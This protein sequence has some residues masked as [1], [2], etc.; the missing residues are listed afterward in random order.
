MKS[1][2]TTRHGKKRMAQR[3]IS[4]NEIDLALAYGRHGYS[5][6]AEVYVIGKKEILFAQLQGVCL[7]Q[8]EGLHV[9]IA[10]R[11]ITV[12][13]NKS[14]QFRKMCRSRGKSKG[15]RRSR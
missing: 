14:L 5:R 10:D 12:F 6:G 2:A 9:V 4:N 7:Q 11:L 8:Y 1:F 3:C 15:R 13:R